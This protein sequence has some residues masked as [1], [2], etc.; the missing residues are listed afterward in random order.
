VLGPGDDPEAP[1]LGGDLVE[2]LGLIDGDVAVAFA[3]YHEDGPRV[4]PGQ[5][6]SDGRIIA[7]EFPMGEDEEQPAEEPPEGGW[8]VFV[9]QT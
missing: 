6:L 7:S 2:E 8:M 1:G 3:V 5:G 9:D 4:H